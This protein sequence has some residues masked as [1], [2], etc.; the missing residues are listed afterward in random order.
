MNYPP[1][2]DYSKMAW[3]FFM[4]LVMVQPAAG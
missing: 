2:P 1:V 4:L 3:A